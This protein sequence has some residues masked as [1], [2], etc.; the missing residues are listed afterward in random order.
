MA[1]NQLT[2]ENE[3]ELELADRSALVAKYDALQRLKDNDDFRVLVLQ[4]Y[5]VDRAVELTSL[6][7]TDYGFKMRAQIMESLAAISHFESYLHMIK[8]TGAPVKEEDY[9]DDQE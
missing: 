4:G 6:V 9:E 5:I 3:T 1:I 7:S 8:N 2:V